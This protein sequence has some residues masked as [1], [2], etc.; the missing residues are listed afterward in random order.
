[1]GK[2]NTKSNCA[3]ISNRSK[4]IVGVGASAIFGFFLLPSGICGFFLLPAHLSQQ[5]DI[6]LKRIGK[7]EETEENT[8]LIQ[9]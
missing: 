9:M 1:M 4:T 2:K 8:S 6:V 3:Y 5:K 7:S